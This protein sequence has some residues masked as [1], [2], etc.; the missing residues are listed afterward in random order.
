MDLEE[1]A[2]L[3]AVR[4]LEQDELAENK[5]E[6]FQSQLE[7]EQHRLKTIERNRKR[8]QDVQI[9]ENEKFKTT[10]QM[11]EVRQ[12]EFLKRQA[13]AEEQ[14]RLEEEKIRMKAAKRQRQLEKV[15][16]TKEKR[17]RERVQ[18]ILEKEDEREAAKE[19]AR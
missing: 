16:L 1:A 7:M 3:M 5:W 9:R 19:I 15:R 17:E 12:E 2:E 14:K 18:A 4:Q 11:F 10:R 6:G 13:E 8:I